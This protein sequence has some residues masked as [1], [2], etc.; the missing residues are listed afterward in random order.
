[1]IETAAEFDTIETAAEF[2]TIE[3][4]APS[5]RYCTTSIYA[6]IQRVTG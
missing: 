4:A 2:D 3:T 5:H 6:D 1:M